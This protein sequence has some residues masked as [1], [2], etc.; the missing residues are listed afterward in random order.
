MQIAKLYHTHSGADVILPL[1]PQPLP[2]P[3][4]RAVPVD[5]TTYAGRA[6][7]AIQAMRRNGYMEPLYEAIYAQAQRLD[8]L[9]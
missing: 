4:S 2:V 7:A 5:L 8:E 1:P 6:L 3:K 9:A